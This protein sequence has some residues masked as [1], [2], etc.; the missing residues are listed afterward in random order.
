MRIETL[1]TFPEIFDNYMKLSIMKNAQN[2]KLLQY[3]SY[4]LRDWT[5]DIHHKTDDKPYGGG[6]GQ[7]M[8][9][10]PIFKAHDEI[11]KNQKSKP[12]VVFM[13]PFGKKYND[14]DA[15]IL[16]ECES[17]LFICGHYEGIDYRAYSLA[18]K[19]YSIGDFV[20][21]GGE[22]ASLVVIDSLVRK[23]PGVLGAENGAN[24]E[25]FATGY[26]EA[27][28]YTRPACFR[29]MEVPDVLLSGDHKKIN[30]WKKEKSIE[31]TKKFRPDLFDED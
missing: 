24:D 7:L 23:I 27:P 1:S 14:K 4:N 22:L 30:E 29:G 11:V 18:D 16:S 8:M 25:S 12:L 21:T 26:L 31:M 17:L 2:K 5:N 6:K 10:E 19:I 15:K 9:C 20:L 13:A 28:Q 3:K